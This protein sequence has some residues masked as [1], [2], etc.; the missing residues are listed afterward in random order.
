MSSKQREGTLRALFDRMFSKKKAQEDTEGFRLKHGR[1]LEINK[2]LFNDE[3][4]TGQQ[5]YLAAGVAITKH[6][7]NTMNLPTSSAA[8]L[9]KTSSGK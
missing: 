3:D 5:A 4:Q 9:P 2:E 7:Y 8:I 6:G 1:G